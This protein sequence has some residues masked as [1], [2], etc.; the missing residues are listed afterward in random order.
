MSIETLSQL[1]IF[2]SAELSQNFINIGMFVILIKNIYKLSQ[3]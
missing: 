2:G 1:F 3:Y